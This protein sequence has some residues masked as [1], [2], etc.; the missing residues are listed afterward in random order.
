MITIVTDGGFNETP[1]TGNSIVKRFKL[2]I[3]TALIPGFEKPWV[4][5]NYADYM[6]H[7]NTLRGKKGRHYASK[8]R[9]DTFKE[10]LKKEFNN[11]NVDPIEYLISLYYQ[12]WISIDDMCERVGKLWF[13]YKDATWLRMFVTKTLNWTLRENTEKTEHRKRK[14]ETVGKE[15]RA[16]SLREYNKPIIEKQIISITNAIDTIMSTHS[17]AWSTYNEEIYNSLPNNTK[18]CLYL[19]Q[20]FMWVWAKEIENLFSV[21]DNQNVICSVVETKLAVLFASNN[22]SPFRIYA[23]TISEIRKMVKQ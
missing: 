21:E 19:L 22:I 1:W 17:Q 3:N 18:K 6:V 15:K 10:K 11:Q 2:E 8:K 4:I 14:E 13:E 12:Y 20:C 5:K 9:L 23:R 7:F 16:N